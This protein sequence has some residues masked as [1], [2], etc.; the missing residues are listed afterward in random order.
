MKGTAFP[1]G[2][3][4]FNDLYDAAY[5]IIHECVMDEEVGGLAINIGKGLSILTPLVTILSCFPIHPRDLGTSLPS[6]LSNQAII[7]IPRATSSRI[8]PL[9]GFVS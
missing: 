9:C 1:V 3:A 5:W 8:N 7:K 4:S 6:N 2:T